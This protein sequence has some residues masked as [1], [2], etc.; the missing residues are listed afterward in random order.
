MSSIRLSVLDLVPLIGTEDAAAA[1]GEAVKLAQAAEKLGYTRYWLAEHHDM[2]SVVSSSPEVLL[3]HVGART[4]QI[5]LGSGAVLLPYYKPYKVAESFH[6]LASLYPGRIDLGI[7]RAP[8]GSAHVSLALGDNFLEGVRR[9]PE[10]LEALTAL[11]KDDYRIDGEKVSARPLPP[12][13]PEL[14]LLGTNEKS[15]L[16]ASR[17]GAGY[18]FGHFM[19][20]QDGPAIIQRYREDYR[21]SGRDTEPKVIVAV[22]AVCAETEEKA[23]AYAEQGLKQL[24][25]TSGGGP[26]V[27]QPFPGR[28][29]VGSPE[30][31]AAKLSEL[32]ELY[33]TDEF[34]IVTLAP[35]YEA[36]IRSYELLADKLRIGTKEE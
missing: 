18:V 3:A 25:G 5:R 34:M 22:R 4:E 16:F 27:Q 20:D 31:V 2:Q 30:G 13:P 26:A 33:G 15:A 7:G 29:L 23:A 11:L 21:A 17:F 28:A 24:F 12:I 9:M 1:L 14:W 36:R 35:T 10:S 8:G 19:S 6:M 32:S